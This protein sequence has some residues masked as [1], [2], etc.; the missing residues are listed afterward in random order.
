MYTYNYNVI[1]YTIMYSTHCIKFGNIILF[2]VKIFYYFTN[3][4]R[5]YSVVI[6]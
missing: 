2:T 5:V 3:R 1:D 6:L 4:Y